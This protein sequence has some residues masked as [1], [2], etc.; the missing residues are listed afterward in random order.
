MNQLFIIILLCVL[1]IVY[2]LAALNLTLKIVKYKFIGTTLIAVIFAY[3]VCFGFALY[4]NLYP[5]NVK[6]TAEAAKEVTNNGSIPVAKIAASLFDAF[7]MLGVAF[8][9]DAISGYFATPINGYNFAFGLGYVIAS[10]GALIFA[11][12]TVILFIS[13]SAFAKLSNFFKTINIFKNHDMFYIFSDAR[14]P[15]AAKVGEE[16]K[17]RGIVIMMVTRSSLKTQE[18]T[19]YRDSLIIKK[20]DV[21]T[22]NFSQGLCSSLFRRFGRKRKVYVYGLF[23]ND[24]SSIQLANNFT[25]AIKENKKFIKYTE[26]KGANVKEKELEALK[27]FKVFVSYQETDIDINNNYSKETFRIVNTLSQYDIISTEFIINN[28]IGDFIDLDKIDKTPE[29]VFHVSFLGF[30][31]IN[32]PIYE[33]MTCAYQLWGDNT[34]KVSYHIVDRESKKYCSEQNNEYTKKDNNLAPFLYSVDDYCNGEDLREYEVIDKHIKNLVEKESKKRFNEKGFE[35]FIISICDTTTDIQVSSL[36]R[37]ALLKNVDKTKLKNTFIF[38]R[39]ANETLRNNFIENNG[40]YI[41]GQEELTQ[42][43]INS[44]DRDVAPIIVFGESALMPKYISSHYNNLDDLAF[45]AFQAYENNDKA[46]IKWLIQTKMGV[47][48]NM[49]TIYS[50]RTKMK[51]LG[52]NLDT[53]Y[54]L[55]RANGKAINK[56]EYIDDIKKQIEDCGFPQ[57]YDLKNNV[58]KLASLEHNRWVASSYQIFK[59]SPLSFEEFDQL[60]ETQYDVMVANKDEDFKTKYAGIKHV[61]MVDNKKLIEIGRTIAK[62]HPQLEEKAY[63]LTFYNDIKAMYLVFEALAKINDRVQKEA[64]S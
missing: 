9:K 40:K 50:L 23:S 56:E 35:L 46:K 6:E 29:D 53:K 57:K 47:N 63:N 43:Y 18:G 25:K 39:V 45:A 41:I 28:Q 2:L 48:T 12:I 32:R 58:I 3:L 4:A 19:E 55:T 60:N 36:L 20:F 16:L 26:D 13:N 11:S 14:V 15:V 17:K 22:E 8:D 34:H 49:A 30:G 51:L 27:N 24:E 31:K 38:V 1:V 42:N 33:K 10:V 64:N 21:R 44:P 52:Y 37:K 61:C 5:I 62:Q 59:Y 7:K 54:K